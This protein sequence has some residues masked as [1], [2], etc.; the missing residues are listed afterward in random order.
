LF[1]GLVLAIP[2]TKL[3]LLVVARPPATYFLWSNNR[4][5]NNL[6]VLRIRKL[7]L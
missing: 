4:L 5:S 7:K 2:N 1:F 3:G 6:E